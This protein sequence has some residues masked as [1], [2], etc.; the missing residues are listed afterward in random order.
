MRSSGAVQA[1]RVLHAPHWSRSFLEGEQSAAE[2][3][4]LIT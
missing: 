2:V 1:L 4:P 3:C